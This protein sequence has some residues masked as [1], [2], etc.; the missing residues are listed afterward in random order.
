MNN[1][2]NQKIIKAHQISASAYRWTHRAMRLLLST[3]KLSINTHT[4]KTSW[5][6]GDIF[7]FNHFA[8]FET[9]IPQYLIY[10]ETG[11]YSRSIASNELFSDHFWGGYLRKLGGIANDTNSLMYH[12]SRDILL[13][14]KLIAFPEGGI[15]K[16]RRSIDKK[17]RYAVYSRSQHQRRK[18]HTGAAV[19][20]LGVA[21]F[22]SVVRSLDESGEHR[23]LSLWAKELGFENM[24]LMVEACQKPTCLVPCNITFYPLRV[25]TNILKDTATFLFQHIRK[26]FNEELVIEGNLLLKK[27]DMDI[28]LGPA[29]TVEDYWTKLE[30]SIA[31]AFI[32]KSNLSLSDILNSAHDDSDWNKQ[33]FRL[34]YQ[35]NTRKIRDAFMHQIYSQVTINIAHIASTVIMQLIADK[36]TVCSKRHFHMTLY[37]SI[38]L[39]QKNAPLQFHTTLKNPCI[40]RAV[41]TMKSTEFNQFLRNAYHAELLIDDGENYIFSEKICAKNNFD[42]IRIRNP[43]AVYSNE[44]KPIHQVQEAVQEAVLFNN[45]A[46]CLELAE[47]FFDDEIREFRWDR[48]VY[49]NQQFERINQQQYIGE[50]A[51]KPYL[52]IPKVSNGQSIILTHGLLSTPYEMKG[53]ATK[54]H[55]LGYTVIGCRLKGHGTSPWDLHQKRWQDWQQSL[56]QSINVAMGYSSNIHLVGFSTGGLLSL[57]MAGN[58]KAPIKSVVSCGTPL[59]IK[60]PKILFAKAGHFSNIA[61]RKI[62][63]FHGL[64][65]K[66]NTPEHPHI[67]YQHLPLSAITQLLILIKSTKCHLKKIQCPTL[68]IHADNDPVSSPKSMKLLLDGI[69][70]KFRSYQWVSSTRHGI[71]YENTDNCQ[72][73]IIDFIKQ[74]HK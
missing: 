20:G 17:G 55:V 57:I 74:Q 33:L 73:S 12:V 51:A 70:Q 30:S 14:Y 58:Q 24:G 23:T 52:L 31:T 7:L 2:I 1:L 67:N 28:Q 41:L 19:I 15:V 45:D 64:P 5:A 53:L 54:L 37:I 36:K 11:L 71:L 13:G 10:Q 50:E 44:V 32:K 47:F 62:T 29:I 48:S 4:K 9:F 35:R 16:D 6:T 34:S 66:K 40:Y 27:T 56:K 3:L 69:Q 25:K 61:I 8:R 43:I 60:N 26:R 18:L 42:T 38:K 22:K 39:L 65:F 68:I 59:E 21:I 46:Q 72:Q 49:L 63:R